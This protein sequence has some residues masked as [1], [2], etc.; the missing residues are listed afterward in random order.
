MRTCFAPF[1]SF[2]N[3][4][5]VLCSPATARSISL[6]LMR[7]GLAYVGGKRRVAEHLIWAFHYMDW[8]LSACLLLMEPHSEKGGA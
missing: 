3:E 8:F 2:H 6:S 4:P 1:L 5:M 7:S